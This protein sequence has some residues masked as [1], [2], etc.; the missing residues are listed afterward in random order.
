MIKSYRKK[1]PASLHAQRLRKKKRSTPQKKGVKSR[2]RGRRQSRHMLRGGVITLW[3]GDTFTPNDGGTLRRAIREMMENRPAALARY[4]PLRDWNT[5]RV[6][7]FTFAFVDY[8][9]P[10]GQGAG[11]DDD[12]TGWDTSAATI[13]YR[14]F[15]NCTTFDQPLRFDT[16]LV[17]RMGSMFY[18]C[19]AFDQPLTFNTHACRDFASMFSGCT[20]F[21]QPLNF[22][23]HNARH[24]SYMFFGC[25]A[26]NQPLHQWYH[27]PSANRGFIWYMFAGCASFQSPVF[28]MSMAEYNES[29]LS[30]TPLG[31]SDVMQQALLRVA[32]R[33]RNLVAQG[34]MISHASVQAARALGGAPVLDA[35]RAAL[36][37]AMEGDFGFRAER[38]DEA[39]YGRGRDMANASA[40][41]NSNKRA[42]GVELDE[43]FDD[44]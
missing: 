34:R 9:F 16:H 38:N 13:M 35:E 26:F 6:Q 17:T 39:V 42:R 44:D 21:N 14:M 40:A 29:R 32:G 4:G 12:V 30:G 2:S 20:A 22:D 5:E 37:L 33:E 27:Q 7:D 3:N 11:E 15:A 8:T 18:G 19:T 31:Q 10:G 1:S 25:T 36:A 41:A 28:T 24:M 43:H 23:T